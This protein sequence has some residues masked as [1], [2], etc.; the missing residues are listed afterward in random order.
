MNGLGVAVVV[1]AGFLLAQADEGMSGLR[2]LSTV[3][4]DG[5]TYHVQGIDVEGDR[6]WLSAV[7]RAGK[8]GLL[9]E[10]SLTSGRRVRSVEVHEGARYHP[11]GITQEGDSLWIPVAE[12]R[13]NSTA[14]LQRRSK[15]TLALE[16]SFVVQDHIGAVA[17]VP[18]GLLGANW[19]A[20]SFY[21]WDRS[22]RLLRKLENASP[23]AVQ[24]MKF[25]AGRLVVGGLLPDRTG[26]VDWLEWPLLRPV[27]QL[28]VGHTDRGV[29]YTHEGLAIRGD[30]LWFV[31]ED[32]AS[33]LFAFRLLPAAP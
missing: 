33:R 19:D 4:L 8:R 17:L 16:S 13:R 5:E 25:D 28:P 18:E 22:G 10:Y 30:R 26:R 15:R 11:G 24:D 6:L 1:A 12:Y 3:P 2:L 31:P 23:L 32:D 7:D 14:T 9:F 21:L 27:R 20:R 29:A